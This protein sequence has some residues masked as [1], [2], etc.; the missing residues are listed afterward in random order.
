MSI[1][2][3]GKANGSNSCR[4]LD[5]RF[6]IFENIRNNLIFIYIF[7]GV[8]AVQVIIIFFGGYA[9]QTVPLNGVQW[10]VSIVIGVMAIPVGAIARLIPNEVWFF[11]KRCMPSKTTE[12][13]QDPYGPPP[14]S[15][16]GTALSLDAFPAPTAV[17]SPV[18]APSQQYLSPTLQAVG[19]P[20]SP[21]AYGSASY[22]DLPRAGSPSPSFTSG[23][24]PP[25][26]IYLT[27]PAS[28]SAGYTANPGKD[29][30]LYAVQQTSPELSL[31]RALRG[32]RL[33]GEEASNLRPDNVS[34]HSVSAGVPTNSYVM[35]PA[36][37]APRAQQ[38]W[39]AIRM[40]V[41]DGTI[42]RGDI[43][44]VADAAMRAHG[45]SIDAMPPLSVSSAPIV[46]SP[47]AAPQFT[48]SSAQV[49]QYA[50]QPAPINVQSPPVEMSQV[51]QSTV[52]SEAVLSAPAPSTE[53]PNY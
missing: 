22:Q 30:W 48:I 24:R 4:R 10:A 28:L 44:S 3:S 25:S 29:R 17:G 19:L 34:T 39:G 14:L 36:P 1:L 11:W 6:N 42:R 5:S 45:D 31:F 21:A 12:V 46:S 20:S 16:A 52:P 43:G 49:N 33:Y 37:S 23:N 7:F 13:L 50:L 9:F 32:G 18:L 47:L 41:A 2:I 53:S 38:R 51:R 35:S 26:V 27:P 40:A 8:I 15:I